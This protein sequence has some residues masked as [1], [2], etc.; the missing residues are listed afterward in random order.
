[1]NFGNMGTCDS[2]LVTGATCT[3][4][5]TNGYA[6]T[7]P[8]TQSCSPLGPGTSAF[9]NTQTC[10]AVN[11]AA[12]SPSNGM[13]NTCDSS[14]MPGDNCTIT[15]TGGAVL[16]GP[17]SQKCLGTGPGLS[18]FENSQTC[19]L[20]S[21]PALNPANGA[22]NTCTS[23]HIVGDTCT[24]TCANGYTLIGGASQMCMAGNGSTAPA[25][26]NTQSCQAASCAN[27]SPANGTIGTCNNKFTNQSCSIACASGFVLV[28]P[29]TQ[30]CTATGPDASAFPNSQ[31]CVLKNTTCPTA[32][33]TLFLALCTDTDVG[34][35]CRESCS[36]AANWMSASFT[37]LAQGNAFVDVCIRNASL[38]SIT[39][40][41]TV[42]V[43]Y[44]V[45]RVQTGNPICKV[46]SALRPCAAVAL[47]VTFLASFLA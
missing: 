2:S 30:V 32:D 11:C 14:K 1:V 9:D 44:V 3:I 27:L 4:A 36:S 40:L 33:V 46:S 18:A 22:A 45:G 13:A 43:N 17:T 37:K 21:C 25:F 7:G 39:P 16:M 5:C 15:C 28:G 12:L 6:V 35:E 34:V 47:L 24:I 10:V 41:T 26:Q 8:S 20:P 38:N 42:N 31:R 29:S 19:Q 23:G